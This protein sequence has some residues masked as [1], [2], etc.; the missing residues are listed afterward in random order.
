MPLTCSSRVLVDTLSTATF[1]RREPAA[2]LRPY[3]AFYW[4]S[5]P[6]TDLH[7]WALPTYASLLS[8]NLT[9]LPWYSESL[10]GVRDSFTRSQVFG[11]LTQARQ[12]HYPAGTAL[13]GVTFQP[14]ALARLLERP[15][16]ELA[17]WSAEVADVRP[18]AAVESALR[19]TPTFAGR[20]ALLEA[21]L[22]P[23]FPPQPLEYR[24]PL[25]QAALARLTQ[26]SGPAFSVAQVADQLSVTPKSLTRYFQQFVGAG[27]KR[28]AQL[29]RF[30]AALNEYRSQGQA[31]DFEAAGYADFAHFARASRR[32]IGQPLGAL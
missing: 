11:H 16:Q 10:T 14:G 20:V 31:F 18:L 25:V 22:R 7:S 24:Y 6:T 32:L 19:S 5:Q 15:A 3:V 8:F 9:Q 1:Q 26:P 4:Q 30:K 12:C 13:F 29:A 2:D 27:P 21:Y 23:C 17:N 28:C